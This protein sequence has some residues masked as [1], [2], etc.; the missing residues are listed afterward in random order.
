M[1]LDLKAI[2][3]LG[4][5]QVRCYRAVKISE[6]AGSSKNLL[7]GV[8]SVTEHKLK[9]SAVS[10]RVKF[11][12]SGEIS[13]TCIRQV[14]EYRLLEPEV[15]APITTMKCTYPFGK[16]PFTMFNFQYRSRRMYLMPSRGLSAN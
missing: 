2:K 3:N 7:L 13:L 15:I 14:D 4:S 8:G 5:I 9:G 1:D 10:Q 6:A 12:H 11:A 16:D